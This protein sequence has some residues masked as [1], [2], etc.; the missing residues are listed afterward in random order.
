MMDRMARWATRYD[1]S[2]PIHLGQRLGHLEHDGRVFRAVVYDKG[3]WVLHMLSGVVG[4]EAFFAG[5]RAFLAR[6]RYG[7]AGTEDFRLALEGASGR[8]LR[9]YFERWIYGTGLPVLVWSSRTERTEGGFRTTI[10]V[11]PQGLPGPVPLLLAAT[12][13]A[14][15]EALPVTLGTEGGSWTIDTTQEPRRVILNDDRGLLA[16]VERVARVPG[17][18]Q[19]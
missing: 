1:S 13:A 19:R 16:R 6:F 11:R 15:S 12:T 8:D 10:D 7:K 14:G 3:A 9:P 4:D 5:V 18:L 2:G 17:P